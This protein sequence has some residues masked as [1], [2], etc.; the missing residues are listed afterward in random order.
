MGI[1]GVIDW[2]RRDRPDPVVEVGPALL[3]VE[4]RRHPRATRMTL[5]LAPDGQAVR[6][7]MPR[8]GRTDDALGFARSRADWI[9]AQ[10]DQHRPHEALAPGA[11]IWF[12]GLP[13]TVDWSPASRRNPALEG[14]RLVCGGPADM[15]ERRVQRWLERQALALMEAD[16]AFYCDRAG[17]APPALRLSRAQRRWGSCSS[18]G[19]VRINWRLVQ[20]PDPVRRSVVAHEVAHLVHFDHSPRFHR[21]LN[22]LYDGDLAAADAWLKREGRTLYARFG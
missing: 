10:L 16:L 19:T 13:V 4:I 14:E 6:V 12:R 18:K 7:T 22:Q 2:L 17:L 11:T 1:P 20:A 5:R 21:L 15:L 8:W 9:A 3:P